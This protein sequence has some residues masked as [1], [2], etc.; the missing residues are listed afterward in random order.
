MVCVRRHLLLTVVILPCAALS[1]GHNDLATVVCF[2]IDRRKPVGVLPKT[3]ILK[4]I[5]LQQRRI[6]IMS[7]T[8][9]LKIPDHTPTHSKENL[10]IDNGE[11]ARRRLEEWRD[12]SL[13]RLHQTQEVAE[14]L[15]QLTGEGSD[16][17]GNV[18]VKVNSSG[19]L[20]DVSMGSAVQRQSAEHTA[21][22]VKDAYEA[23]RTRLAEQ[24]RE[25][26]QET[27]GA[28]S[29]T[30]QAFLRNS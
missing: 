12:R 15:Q 21:R 18:T 11:S 22:Q 10:V 14:S 29:E 3:I 9:K 24:V 16:L 2:A 5:S 7:E 8:H 4:E 28:D 20:L 23:A 1:T 25:Q 19:E 30:A 6:M 13:A 27:L 17:N 26:V